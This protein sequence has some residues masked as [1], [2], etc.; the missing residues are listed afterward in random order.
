M[1]LHFEEDGVMALSCL[2]INQQ[3]DLLAGLDMKHCHGHGG[4]LMH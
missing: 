3:E 4:N 1:I 2:L